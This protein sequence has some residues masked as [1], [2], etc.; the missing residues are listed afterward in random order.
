[1]AKK[2]KCDVC[3][4]KVS[5][6]VNDGV[7]VFSNATTL[8]EETFYAWEI[9]NPVTK[10]AVFKQPFTTNPVFA[11]SLD[12]YDN[13][14]VVAKVKGDVELTCVVHEVDVKPIADVKVMY[15]RRS[16]FFRFTNITD[17][18]GLNFSWQVQ[19][20]PK[21]KRQWKNVADITGNGEKIFE[22]TFDEG[23]DYRVIAIISTDDAGYSSR[24]VAEISAADL[25]LP[26]I[27]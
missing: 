27:F 5:S 1:M 25:E 10:K 21:S 20:K 17:I 6:F 23:N 3:S 7:R 14:N 4:M 22:Y 19:F 16:N 8:G 24:V 11:Y 12:K 9:V 18:D 26:K 15:A 13:M 2:S